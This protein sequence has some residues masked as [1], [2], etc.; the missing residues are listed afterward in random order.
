[1][2]EKERRKV[3]WWTTKLEDWGEPLPKKNCPE[4]R[5]SASSSRSRLEKTWRALDY[6]AY[7]LSFLRKQG[8]GKKFTTFQLLSWNN[9]CEFIPLNS[10]LCRKGFWEVWWSRIHCCVIRTIHD[11]SESEATNAMVLTSESMVA[12]GSLK[13][14]QL[15]FYYPRNRIS[16]PVT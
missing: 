7:L 1:M 13:L 3:S 5:H 16:S 11:V 14:P 8:G 6:Y 10:V 2:E 9:W 4:R 12:V 15:I